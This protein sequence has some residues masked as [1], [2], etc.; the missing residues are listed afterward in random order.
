[1]VKALRTKTRSSTLL[2]HCATLTQSSTL[3]KRSIR[4]F[5]PSHKMHSLFRFTVHF[6]PPVHLGLNFTTPICA[7]PCRTFYATYAAYVVS[8]QNF[9]PNPTKGL[10][11]FRDSCAR[12]E[13]PLLVSDSV[14]TMNNTLRI[15]SFRPAIFQDYS[16]IKE[17]IS[18]VWN[19]I[20]SLEEH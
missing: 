9:I 8:F 15:Q 19:E 10:Y 4:R 1:M 11:I 18:N 16:F 12:E 13:R 17:Y 6:A 14:N 3:F 5:V 7:Q 2:L 20:C